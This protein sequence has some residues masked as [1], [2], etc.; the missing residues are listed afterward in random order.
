MRTA[1]L[2]EDADPLLELQNVEYSILERI[3]RSRK[4]GILTLGNMSLYNQ[5]N[6]D[7]KSVFHYKKHMLRHGLIQKQYF[8]I[9]SSTTDQN[10]VGTLLQLNKFFRKVKPTQLVFCEQIVNLLKSQPSYRMPVMQLRNYFQDFDNISKITKSSGFR[11]IIKNDTVSIYYFSFM[12]LRI[13]DFVNLLFSL[14]IK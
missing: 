11:K 8:F 7:A 3:G 14:N 1:V 12:N 2:L 6:M 4:M 13:L 10:K 5:F 9:R